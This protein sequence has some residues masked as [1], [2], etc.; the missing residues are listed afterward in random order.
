MFQVVIGIGILL[1]VL[2][3]FMLFRIGTLLD[4]VKGSNQKVVTKSNKVNAALFVVLLVI[5]FGWIFIYSYVYFD[6]YNLPLASEHGVETDYMFWV[7]MAITG[8]VF[9]ITHILLFIFPIRYSYE[10]NKRALFFPENH[11]LELI[12]TIVPAVVLSVLIFKGLQVWGDI[13]SKAPEDA[14]V[15]EVMGQQFAWTPRYPGSDN[16]LGDFDYRLIGDDNKMGVDFTD[17]GSYDDFIPREIHLPKGKPVLFKIRARD[18]IHSVYAPHFRVKMDAVPGMP[19]SFHFVPTKTTA[20]MRV[21]TGNAE[22]NYELAC[23]EICGRGHFAMRMI[24][25]V[26]TPEEYEKWKSEQ[27]SLVAQNEILFNLVPDDKKEL[28]KVKGKV[29]TEVAAVES[30]EEV[31]K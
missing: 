17:D 30:S 22:F 25:V 18:V 11:K 14:E 2:I 13:T 16:R 23:A 7:T 31:K 28:A 10:E 12:W 26:D 27:T 1:V 20:E 5:G 9:L 4:V 21:E 6:D 3:L 8:V 19:T 15:V 29:K 24:I